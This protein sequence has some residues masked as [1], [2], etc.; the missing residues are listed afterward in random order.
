MLIQFSIK[1]Y[2][3]FKDL[4][5]L[6]LVASNYDKMN[7]DENTFI[8]KKL[9]YRL[10]KS[11][12]VYGAN[13]SGKSKFFEAFQTFR[14]IVFNSSKESQAEDKIQVTP[15]L[16]DSKSE[17]EPTSFEIILI[18]GDVQFRYG[19]ETNKQK[20]SKEW[21]YSKQQ[22]KENEI[23]YRTNQKFEDSGRIE[24]AKDLISKKMI[25]ENALFLSVLAQFND[26]T[27][28][29]V[30]R[31]IRNINSISGIRQEG[32][33]GYTIHQIESEKNLSKNEIIKFLN[34]ADL[35]IE[36]LKVS[37]L[38]IENL[39]EDMPDSLKEM[40]R[41]SSNSKEKVNF[42]EDVTAFRRKFNNQRPLKE[43]VP[44]SMEED[45]SSGTRKYF[46]LSGPI[47]DTLKSGATLF[48]DELDSQLHP[49]LVKHLIKLFNS[50]ESNPK[51]AQLIFNTHDIN[52]LNTRVFRRDQIWFTE[53]DNLGGAHLFS[54]SDIKTDN[55]TKIRSDENYERNYLQGKYG[56]IPYISKLDFV[57]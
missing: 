29:N 15:F 27:A 18:N 31:N 49:L 13:A 54:L 17:N 12:V 45:E 25:R 36:D 46:A 24:M 3:T 44:F 57:K 53:K 4:S 16:L 28:K 40:I 42:Y 23:F 39:P 30:L 11:V 8:T 34:T 43:L 41:K 32:Y 55:E 35:G 10:L 6:S 26:K 33:E 38:D 51:N 21:L 14:S 20:V 2:K 52:L 22:L 56:A 47:L 9:K 7:L 19:F 37:K 48:V 5:T 1:N 50:K